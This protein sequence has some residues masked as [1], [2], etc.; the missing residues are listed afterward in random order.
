MSDLEKQF[1]EGIDFLGITALEDLLQDGVLDCIEDFKNAAIKVW[2]L[3]GDKKETASKIGISSGMITN[4]QDS[5]AFNIDAIE[6]LQ[7]KEQIE[8]IHNQIKQNPT[9]AVAVA[10]DG[11]VVEDKDE[12]SVVIEGN[13]LKISGSSMAVIYAS[14]DLHE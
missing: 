11:P 5:S 14:P 2:M 13:S 4:K 9:E 6:F 3:T 8:T 10:D 1:E 7:L 12:V